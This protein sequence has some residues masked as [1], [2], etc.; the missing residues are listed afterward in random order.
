MPTQVE[1]VPGTPVEVTLVGSSGGINYSR[2]GDL[3]VPTTARLGLQ[4]ALANLTFTDILRVN[5]GDGKITKAVF[6]AHREYVRT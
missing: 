6:T 2:V 5:N 4:V 3:F 1:T